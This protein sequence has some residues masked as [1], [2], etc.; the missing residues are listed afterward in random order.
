METIQQQKNV[1]KKSESTKKPKE[2]KGLYKSFVLQLGY[3]KVHWLK[4][5]RINESNS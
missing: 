1:T 5:E 3:L 2:L 4:V